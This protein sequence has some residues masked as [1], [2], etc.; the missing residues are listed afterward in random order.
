VIV[1]FAAP[2]DAVMKRNIFEYVAG[3]IVIVNVCEPREAAM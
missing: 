1:R 2:S 3:G